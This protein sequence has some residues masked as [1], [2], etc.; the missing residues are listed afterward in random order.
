MRCF[1][2]AEAG[3]N[4]NGDIGLAKELIYAASQVGADAVKFQTFNVDT[5]VNKTALKAQY[6]QEKTGDG[7]QY[8]MLKA[9]E[10]SID[11]HYELSELATSLDIEFLSTG[12]DVT[13]IDF[14]VSLG[15]KRL[16][17]PSGEITNM[18][19]LKH[20]ANTRL[21]LIISTGMCYL[22]EVQAALNVVLPF[23]EGE[24]KEKLTLLHCT[25]NYP[26][27]LQDVNLRAMETMQEHFHLPIGYSDHTLGSLVPTLAIAMGA[28]II[29]KHFTLDKTLPGPDQA[30][31]MT[32]KEFADMI[33][34]IRNA[35]TCL[36]NSIKQP[37]PNELPVRALVRRSVTLKHDLPKGASL[38]DNDLTLLRPGHGITPADIQQLIG[39][40]L[41]I[42]LPRGSTLQWEH[43][44]A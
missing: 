10:L 32:P 4:H 18:F 17:I 30:A 26:T 33:L 39:K 25:S 9:L 1:I 27:D 24:E 31:S 6:Q 44:E 5:L 15:V 12:F 2:I 35:E 14:L 13:S 22:Q 43:I 42:D 7:T 3:V 11:A 28:T 21:P 37:S 41:T 20:M 38:S 19:L 29:E 16:K 36:G 8:A 23:Y 40:R 34:L